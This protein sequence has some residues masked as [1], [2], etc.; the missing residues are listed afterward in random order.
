[1]PRGRHPTSTTTSPSLLLVSVCVCFSVFL[2]KMSG[3]WT[4]D[5]I[6]IMKRVTVTCSHFK[7]KKGLESAATV[8]KKQL[9]LN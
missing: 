6:I 1:M 3:W 4:P 5:H 7:F 9:H 2:V 8:L